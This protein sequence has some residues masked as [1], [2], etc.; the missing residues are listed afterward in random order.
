MYAYCVQYV[1]NICSSPAVNALSPSPL[2]ASSSHTAC[3]IPFSRFLSHFHYWTVIASEMYCR[4][5]SAL[6]LISSLMN[7][8]SG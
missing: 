5:Q 1:I 7:G 3:G 6:S 4:L 2:R 8:A